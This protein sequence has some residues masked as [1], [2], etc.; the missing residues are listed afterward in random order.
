MISS[1]EINNC[2]VVYELIFVSREDGYYLLHF[3]DK[4][5]EAQRDPMTAEVSLQLSCRAETK[6]NNLAF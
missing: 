2:S 1:T 4:E 5:S 3:T 6:L